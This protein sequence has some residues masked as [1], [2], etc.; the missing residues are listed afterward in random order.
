MTKSQLDFVHRSL[1]ITNTHSST[2]FRVKLFVS[3]SKS[4][5]A[6]WNSFIWTGKNR[7]TITDPVLPANHGRRPRSQ[8]TTHDSQAGADERDM[9]QSHFPDTR[10][11]TTQTLAGV[12]LIF[13]QDEKRQDPPNFLTSFRKLDGEEGKMSTEN[14][15]SKEM[16]ECVI[17]KEMGSIPTVRGG[18]T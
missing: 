15:L 10:W 8:I 11:E 9:A 16:N 4:L 2:Q 13:K 5:Q 14:R 7:E 12:P 18:G 17:K 3:S 6:I 1:H